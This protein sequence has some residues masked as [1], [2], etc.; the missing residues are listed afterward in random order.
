ME[1][2][3]ENII[4]VIYCMMKR[5][6]SQS[7][8]IHSYVIWQ[9]TFSYVREPINELLTNFS[10]ALYFDCE[11][12]ILTLRQSYKFTFKKRTKQ[13]KRKK[14]HEVDDPLL[15]ISNGQDIKTCVLSRYYVTTESFQVY[16]NVPQMS[17]LTKHCW[18]MVTQSIS[19]KECVI[20]TLCLRMHT[21]LQNCYFPV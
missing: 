9:T 13:K 15:P 11:M 14:H 12:Y 1:Q 8:D 7:K 10:K 17:H 3:I 18:P 21:M 6:T 16:E 20:T 4:A 2:K 19:Q 5:V